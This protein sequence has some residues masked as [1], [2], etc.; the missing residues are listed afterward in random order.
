[1]TQTKNLNIQKFLKIIY[2]QEK[3]FLFELI[4]F[5]LLIFAIPFSET[6]KTV[7]F[8]FVSIIFV[9]RHTYHKKIPLRT[10]PFLYGLIAYLL[11]GFVISFYAVDIRESFKGWLDILCFSIIYFVLIND[12]DDPIIKEIV[13]WSLL[14]STCLAVGWGILVW[15]LLWGK[16][17]LQ[18]ISLGYYNHTAIYLGSIFILS[19]CKLLWTFENKDCVKL[20]AILLLITGIIFVGILLTTSRATILG[21]VSVLIYISLYKKITKRL[22]FS[23]LILLLAGVITIGISH[24]FQK[25]IFQVGPL[26]SRIHIWEAGMKAFK[27]KPF[28]GYGLRCFGKIDDSYYGKFIAD[29]VDHAHNLF[30]NNLVQMGIVG[31]IAL[32]YLL[33]SA[34]IT[35]RRASNDYHRLTIY[36]LLIFVIVNGLFNTTIRWEHAIAFVML[37]YL[38][39]LKNQN[40]KEKVIIY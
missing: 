6:A 39:D 37:V 3:L 15:K 21:I 12:F 29:K 5:I 22:I 10:T 32:L 31:F 23:L 8:L 40:E 30:I 36:S 4:F 2:Q 14:I 25:R 1:M 18:I 26:K 27:D 34:Y 24:D 19:F 35:A 20:K 33:Y 17:Y 28:L 16:P 7:T 11:V 38:L 13:E 9:I